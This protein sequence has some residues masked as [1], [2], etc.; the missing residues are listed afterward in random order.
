[1]PSPSSEQV[2]Q[3][4]E[5]RRSLLAKMHTQQRAAEEHYHWPM[6][7]G[8]SAGALQLRGLPKDFIPKLPPLAKLGVDLGINII[9]P[10]DQ[11]EI[12]VHLPD[13][14][15][16]DEALMQKHQEAI[17]TFLKAFFHQVYTL[18][19]QTPVRDNGQK[20]I[21]LGQAVVAYPFI[22]SR[23]GQHPLKMKN[24]SVREPRNPRER[25]AV[26]KWDRDRK[27]QMPWDVRSV[28]PT[29]VFF[30]L[31]HDPPRDYIEEQELSPKIAQSLYPD[32]AVEPGSESS[33]VKRVIYCS[34]DWYG[35]WVDRVAVLPDNMDGFVKNPRQR[36]WYRIAWSN[37]GD[38]SE[39]GEWEYMAKGMITDAIPLIQMYT[40]N[41]NLQEIAK[42][43]GVF[44]QLKIAAID[45]AAAE[46]ETKDWQVEPA[47]RWI[48]D[49][50]NIQ[51]LEFMQYPGLNPVVFQEQPLINALLELWFGPDILRGRH[52]TDTAS[53]L[54]TRM[55]KAQAVYRP[56]KASLEQM[57]AAVAMDIL[58]SIKEEIG[59][60]VWIPALGGAISLKPEQIPDGTYISINLTPPSEEEKAFKLQEGLS[61]MEAGTL[62]LIEFL[63]NYAYEEH[64]T[65]RAKMIFWDS[66]DRNPI[67]QE[68]LG[69]MV[70]NVLL[71][72]IPGL[73]EQ[74]EQERA[75]KGQL[76][77]ATPRA[78]SATPMQPA[79]LTGARIPGEQGPPSN[80]GSPQDVAQQA[81]FSAVPSAQR[82]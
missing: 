67:V 55:S 47:A 40:V 45:V 38:V 16:R 53:G 12:K 51:N 10:G 73:L 46:A 77:V 74:V 59:E 37:W 28:H 13:T 63:E 27:A 42:S 15:H 80:L 66:L 30:D 2:W 31:F 82:G 70:S 6:L 72:E 5:E 3:W 81:P 21:A 65:E 58:W 41:L 49:S 62:D 50:S 23:L 20:V 60:E 18:R 75:A 8:K 71:Q 48:Y 76:R 57:W 43:L 24:G 36:M 19:M 35:V 26:L 33:G 68:A 69:Q 39:F 29:R 1:M 61:R 17:R 78:Q 11:P 9:L 34:D 22:K 7:Q 4:L 54:R 32:L 14:A 79:P 52:T 56:P 25:Q 44:A 64:P